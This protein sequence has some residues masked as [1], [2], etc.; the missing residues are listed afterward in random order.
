MA[1]G[2][3]LSAR[4]ALVEPVITSAEEGVALGTAAIVPPPSGCCKFAMPAYGPGTIAGNGAGAS[5]GYGRSL[6]WV[7]A[8]GRWPNSRFADRACGACILCHVCPDAAKATK[9]LS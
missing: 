9:W 7:R 3:S 5:S 4:F 1:C 6:S 8:N 2:W